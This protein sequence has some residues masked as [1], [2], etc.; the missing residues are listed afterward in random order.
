MTSIA[1]SAGMLPL[2][3][4]QRSRTGFLLTGSTSSSMPSTLVFWDQRTTGFD[5]S[6]STVE[7]LATEDDSG[8]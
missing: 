4:I 5:L 8:S 1:V 2:Q 3:T 6:G 7:M